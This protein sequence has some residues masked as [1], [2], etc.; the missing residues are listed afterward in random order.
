MWGI[1]I[2]DLPGC[3]GAGRTPA[4]ARDD[5]VSAAREW[6]QHQIEKGRPLP[7]PSDLATLIRSE[8]QANEVILELPVLVDSGRPV[9][10]NISLDAALLEAI[11]KAAKDRG[12][13]RSAFLISAAKEKILEDIG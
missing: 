5:A 9:R 13:T 2:P 7:A 10:A 8:V 6:A 11:D 4:Q 12:L 1:R 3:Y